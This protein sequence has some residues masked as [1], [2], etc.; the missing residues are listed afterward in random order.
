MLFIVLSLGLITHQSLFPGWLVLLPVIGSA[1][2]ISAGPHAFINKTILSNKI[3]VYF[4]LLSYPLYLWHWPLLSFSRIILSEVPSI[5][6]RLVLL[7]LA[8]VLS[9]LTYHFIES[10]IRSSKNPKFITT[11]LIII[12]TAT[13]LVAFWGYTKVQLETSV[14]SP[15]T[16]SEFEAYYLPTEGI[17]T[18][19]R[20]E[21][22]FRHECNF[23]QVDKSTKVNQQILLKQA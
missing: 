8:F 19:N 17:Q 10:P 22:R 15:V 11:T 18:L 9:V 1:L 3:I 23:Y 16:K 13:G 12:L 21:S 4:G 7:V 14:A 5:Y 20:F 6:L 2:V